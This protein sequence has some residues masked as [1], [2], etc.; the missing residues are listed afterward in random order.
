M[1]DFELLPATKQ[2]RQ[3]VRALAEG[4][5]RPVSRYYDDHEHD[6]VQ[7]LYDV[8]ERMGL[9]TFR[10]GGGGKPGADGKKTSGRFLMLTMGNGTP[11][12]SRPPGPWPG[13]PG[14]TGSR[15]GCPCRVLR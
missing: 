6:K 1:I 10:Q 13:E 15:S 4:V 9:K 3:M 11:G 14:R 5:F 7:E 12:S 2:M 8:V